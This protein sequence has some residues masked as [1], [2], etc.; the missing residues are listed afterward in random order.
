MDQALCRFGQICL[1]MAAK[2]GVV[3]EDGQGHGTMPFAFGVEDADFCLVKIQV[4]EAVDMGY[5]KPRI[6][7]FGAVGG[8]LCPS[9]GWAGSR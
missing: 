1:Q 8:F 2:P 4:P 6:S 5:F 3:I 9:V 7:R